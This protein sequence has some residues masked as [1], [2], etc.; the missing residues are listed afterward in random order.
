MVEWD[1]WDLPISKDINVMPQLLELSLENCSKLRKLPA[2]GRLQSLELLII[3]NLDAVKRIG[4]EFCGVDSI[5]SSNSGEGVAFPKLMTLVF[6]N[7]EGWEEWELRVSEKTKIFPQLIELRLEN[8][9]KLSNLPALGR[10]QSLELL[11]IDNLDAVKRIGSE[12]CGVDSIDSSSSGGEVITAAFPKLKKLVF[13]NMEEWEEWELPISTTSMGDTPPALMPCLCELELYYCPVLRALPGLGKLKSLES[14]KICR[15]GA[16]TQM[17]GEFLGIPDDDDDDVHNGGC[18]TEEEGVLSSGGGESTFRNILGN[19]LRSI[20]CL[21]LSKLNTEVKRMGGLLAC[22][23]NSETTGGGSAQVQQEEE[24]EVLF[25]SLKKLEIFHLPMWR[26][27]NLPSQK[28]R[29]VI[30]P[31]LRQLTIRRCDKLQVIPHYMFSQSLKELQ[32]WGCPE[33]G[34]AQP[35]LPPLLESLEFYRNVGFLSNSL[36]VCDVECSHNNN[37][38]YPYLKTVSI[39]SSPHSSLP[40]GFNKLKGIQRLDLSYCDTLDFELKELNHLTM[41]QHLDI[42][43]CPILKERF[44]EGRDW[45]ILSHVPKITIDLEEITKSN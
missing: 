29:V 16:V 30:M 39:W 20:G 3:D 32:I 35:C 13:R 17:G 19:P 18:S 36:P 37:N 2:L 44:G 23:G 24:K 25:P 9:S 34:R 27:S 43:R 10:L 5:D 26:G 41:L 31:L 8:C 38:S 14:L 15:L 33:L 21:C 12:F 45:S 28:D 40:K 4:S 42:N 1:D 7:L 22:F 6:T 11:I